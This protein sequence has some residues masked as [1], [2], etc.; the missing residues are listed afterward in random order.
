MRKT[1]L[2]GQAEM[3]LGV[4]FAHILANDAETNVGCGAL[5]NASLLFDNECQKDVM[6]PSGP[7]CV[8]V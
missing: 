8:I 2:F 7:I 5:R 3:M 6:A 1:Q 4:M